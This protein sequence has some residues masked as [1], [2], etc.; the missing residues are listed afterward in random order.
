MSFVT[1]LECATNEDYLKILRVTT[2]T[3]SEESYTISNGDTVLVEGSNIPDSSEVTTEH[4]ISASSNHLYS[5]EMKDTWGDAWSAG[6]YIEISGMYGNIFFKN[7]MVGLNFESYTLSLYYPIL[8]GQTWKLSSGSAPDSWNSVSFS[9]SAWSDYTAG[10]SSTYSGTQYFRYHFNGIN[11]MAAYEAQFFYRYGLVAYINGVEIFRDHMPSGEITS[12]TSSQGSY[13]EAGYHG[14]VRPGIEVSTTDSVM[15]VELHYESSSNQVNF[16]CFVAVYAPTTTGTQCYVM[17]EGVSFTVSDESAVNSLNL[18]DFNRQSY[19]SVLFEEGSEID[20]VY[21]FNTSYAFVNGVRIYPYTQLNY[22]PTD[23]SFEGQNN[24]GVWNTIF[25]KE[26][27]E[28]TSGT[29]AHA[30]GFF[31]SALYTSYRLRVTGVAGSSLYLYEVQPMVCSVGVPTSIIYTP[32]SYS[33]LVKYDS[34]L[35]RPVVEEFTNCS[36]STELPSGLTLDPVTCIISGNPLTTL[37]ETTFQM[38]SLMNGQTYTGT[39][40][41]TVVG[42]D[43]IMV[44][45]MRSYGTFANREGF[46]IMNSETNEVVYVLSPST[47]QVSNTVMHTYLCL[48]QAQYTVTTTSLLTE[49]MP[50]STMF[51]YAILDDDTTETLISGGHDMNLG[52]NTFYFST[53]YPVQATEGWYYLMGSV[54]TSWT[55]SDMSSFTLG[56]F[57][58]YPDSSNAIQLYKK[59]FSVTNVSSKSG[60]VLNICYQYGVIVYLNGQEVWRNH[61]EGSLSTSSLASNAYESMQYHQIS[62]PVKTI[63]TETESAITYLNEGSNVIAIA[64]VAATASQVTSSFDCSVRIMGS[65]PEAR[66]LDGYS[67]TYTSV[68]GNPGSFLRGHSQFSIS[69]FTCTNH[70]SVSFNN[71]RREWISSIEIQ[72]SPSSLDRVVQFFDFKARNADNEEWTTLRAVTDMTWSLLGQSRK[73]YII[74]SKPYNQY[75]FEN[76]GNEECSW[77][78]S[79]INLFSDPT[80]LDVPEL[81]Y[82]TDIL[83]VYQSIEM[84]EF[85]PNSN[86]YMEF[87]ITPELPEGMVIDPYSGVLSGTPTVL[88]SLSSYTISAKKFT[89]GDTSVSLLIAVVVCHSGKNLITLVAMPD[90]N[91]DQCSYKLHRGKTVDGEIVS[92]NT[93][94]HVSNQLNYADFCLLHDIYTLEVIDSIANGWQKPGGY[95]LTID[96]GAMKFENGQLPSGVFSSVTRFSSYLPFQ[97]NLDSWLVEKFNDQSN[98]DW[99]AV[100]FDDSQWRSMRS[101]M[102][103][104]SQLVTIYLRRTFEIPDIND[105]PV[106]NVRVRY[107]GGIV[108]YFNGHKVARF[109]LI[110]DASSSQISMR[111]HDSNTF[112]VFHIV[113]ATSGGVTGNNVIAFEVHRPVGY[114]SVS[115]ITFDATGVFGVNDCS[116]VL[117]SYSTTESSSLT[118]FTLAEAFDLSPT[119]YGYLPNEVGAYMQWTVENLEGSQFNTYGWQSIENRSGWGFSLYARKESDEWTTTFEGT[120]IS[121][122]AM[123]RNTFSVP[124]GT[125]SFT[126]FRFEVDVPADDTT[127]FSSHYFMYCKI[128]GD[129]VCAD[130]DGFPA[131]ASGQISPSS[132]PYGYSGYSYRTCE[133]TTFSEINTDH[134]EQK[135]PRNLRYT[136]STYQFT[137]DIQVTTGE[138]I[139][140]N[141]IDEF[142]L[143]EDSVL[144]SGLSLNAE[145]GEISGVPTEECDIM[146]LTIMAKNQKSTTFV[147]VNIQIQEGYCP[148]DGNFGRTK[149][150]EKAVYDCALQGS[151]VGTQSRSCILTPT[152]AQW[153]GIS[154]LCVSIGIM[155]TLI[156]VLL[157][158]I[159]VVVFVLLR[160]RKAKAKGGVRRTKKQ[161][162]VDKNTSTVNAVKV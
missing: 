77:S 106:L 83:E 69:G 98:N 53:L 27:Q 6:S 48:P 56:E 137:K 82:S 151:Y 153:Q 132:C 17:T 44:D 149:V 75:R 159:L 91:N 49:W 93:Y 51:I 95:Y 68:N 85:Y 158:I 108:A 59:S 9:D 3:A 118:S 121:L 14:V 84:A 94:F 2:T 38:T 46:E 16:D 67:V 18:F 114:T 55:D 117:D 79:R 150:G 47:T 73:I 42:C 133:G 97:I 101:N 37:E 112:S 105:Y 131:V 135:A 103:G 39:F 134:C 22:A 138:P 12:S 89:G 19:M 145:T 13:E 92:Q 57:G 129:N 100:D 157:I 116:I 70:F 161:L 28:Y 110:D 140:S 62:L 21:S 144:P 1:S 11:E 80:G 120:N 156:V 58:A 76:F 41:L 124:M 148:P 4:C 109:N 63:A 43:H 125:A 81:S 88:S 143:G 71:D 45:I 50:T 26:N 126:E 107:A 74:N 23:F 102:I 115:L 154:G 99:T 139:Y 30:Y 111:V 147:R 25:E 90:V 35:I 24:E 123:S 10:T 104:T 64:L 15:A 29:A 160:M 162:P 7:M 32:A 54:P 87:S 36:L 31:N 142:Y 66:I 152:G 65:E 78:V 34:V 72:M 128:S 20:V 96:M 155:V 60:I 86:Y 40:T 5:F 61:I 113:M 146:V 33:A 127:T 52:F 136:S 122:Q 119:T 130:L 8:K 141:L